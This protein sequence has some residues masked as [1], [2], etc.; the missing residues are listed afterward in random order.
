M[1][2]KDLEEL[3]AGLPA[4]YR[5]ALAE[6]TEHYCRH[7]AEAAGGP[8]MV[9]IL[10]ETASALWAVN[11]RLAGSANRKEIMEDPHHATRRR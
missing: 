2:R 1:E 3:L 5:Y 10:G 8:E 11:A 6:A 9:E 4:S 7:G